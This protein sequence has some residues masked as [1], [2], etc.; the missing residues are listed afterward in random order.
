MSAE[1]TALVG[2]SIPAGGTV[3]CTY[4]VTH[5]EAGSYANTA[6]VTVK[7]NENNTATDTDDETVTV[8]DVLPTVDLTKSALPTTLPEPGG[9]FVF[10]LS[11]HNTS[12][13]AV[14]IDA[15]T[16]DNALSAECTALVGTSIP[17]GGTVSC[18]Y[19]VTHTEAGSYA[20]TASV[21]VEDN[22]NNT[23]TDTDDETVTVTDV[24]PAVELTR[25]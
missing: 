22:E 8:T 19:A 17:A 12:V 10:T 7:D 1:C 18:T 14:T 25:P 21:T 3:S 20:N 4:A 16:D 11:I 24:L 6:S 5:T 2:T 15:L 23:A 13:E 9:D